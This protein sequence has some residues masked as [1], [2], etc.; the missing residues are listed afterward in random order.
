MN[1]F[2]KNAFKAELV[3]QILIQRQ[4][5][6]ASSAKEIL[7]KKDAL[8]QKLEKIKEKKYEQSET[9]ELINNPITIVDVI[10]SLNLSRLDKPG[11]P[12]DEETIF[13]TLAQHW[14]VPFFKI[15][16]L[17]LDLNVVTTTI[18]RSFAMKHLVLPVDVKDGV[19][20][21]AMPDPFNL[22]VLDDMTIASKLRVK[23]V[24]SPKSDIIKLINEFFGFKRSIG[25]I[26]RPQ[27]RSGQLGA[28]CASAICR[29]TSFQRPAYR[30][31]R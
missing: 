2:P 15:D 23:A 31:C 1:K 17:K 18:P 13:E 26:R 14:K 21:V 4:L 28:I 19:L 16:P 20:T 10:A 6:A 24:V 5:L 29:R 27:R 8:L 12:L 11:L 22:E 9:T 30:Q 3:C 7:R 25:S